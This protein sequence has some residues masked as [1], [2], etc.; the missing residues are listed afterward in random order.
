[1]DHLNQDQSQNREPIRHNGRGSWQDT[2]HHGQVEHYATDD[3]PHKH[4]G[5][6]PWIKRVKQQFNELF[7][8]SRD[9]VSDTQH[10]IK[11][12]SDTAIQKISEKPL[13]FLLIASTV[14]FL[15]S[16]IFKRKVIKVIH[17]HQEQDHKHI[18]Q[19]A[20]E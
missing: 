11:D 5:Q 1:M 9:K 7:Y 2:P 14:G 12:Y 10:L 8:D 4:F 19:N 6:K 17:L 3:L 18:R 16:S 13:P 15:L 20:M